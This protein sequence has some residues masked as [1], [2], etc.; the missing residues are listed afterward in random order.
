M[1]PSDHD[2]SQP[3]PNT[4]EDED[5]LR[6]AAEEARKQARSLRDRIQRI[7]S[8]DQEMRNLRKIY[9]VPGTMVFFLVVFFKKIIII[10][11]FD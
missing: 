10:I 11:D 2:T 7:Q 6:K 9:D 1:S 4:P 8:V 5:K 3:K